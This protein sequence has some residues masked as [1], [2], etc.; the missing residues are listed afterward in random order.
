MSRYIIA[1]HYSK[2]DMR[3]WRRYLRN[4][5]PFEMCTPDTKAVRMYIPFAQAL[6]ATRDR[7]GR[8]M[9][10]TSAYRSV[11]YNASIG[12]AKK[13]DHLFQNGG[14]SDVALARKS[15]G[16]LLERIWREEVA[17]VASET[18]LDL[19]PAVGRYPA[20]HFIHMGM[21]MKKSAAWGSW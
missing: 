20:R 3:Q 15:D 12:G 5:T 17:R 18:G 6:Q 8:A 9:N 4:F 1:S 13:S 16:P 14:A 11:K 7:F 21:R 2:V 10:V 19:H